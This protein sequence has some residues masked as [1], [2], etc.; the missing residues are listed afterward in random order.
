[1]TAARG[2]E[3]Y[4]ARIAVFHAFREG[5]MLTLHGRDIFEARQDLGLDG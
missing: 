5:R 1:L 3:I 4:D 2:D